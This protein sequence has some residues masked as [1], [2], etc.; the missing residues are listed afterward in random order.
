M[1]KTRFDDGF[2]MTR[3]RSAL[4]FLCLLFL[5]V[6]AVA[7]NL[8]GRLGLG[9]NHAQVQPDGLL[10]QGMICAGRAS[11]NSAFPVAGVSSPPAPG[12]YRLRFL[13]G[14]GKLLQELDFDPPASP[15]GLPGQ[16]LRSFTFV[17]PF[18]P[19]LQAALVA[20]ELRHGTSTLATLRSSN[21]LPVVA[22]LR[23]A[24]AAHHL[25]PGWV[26]LTWDAHS[27]PTVMVKEVASG[28]TIAVA[29]GGSMDLYT[30]AAELE[31]TLSDG[32]RSL[33]HRLR[34]H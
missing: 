23:Q 26:R 16:E 2:K 24:P 4:V 21:G 32:I 19:S 30:D 22:P 13:D 28:E 15:D 10:V 12:A 5:L 31:L 14:A 27:H 29:E 11:L 1:L 3:M 7:G 9:K 34:V 6:P 25:R 17:L 33:T 18:T 8:M 20:L